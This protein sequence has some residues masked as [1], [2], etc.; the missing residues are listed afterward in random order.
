[1]ISG[2]VYA[3]SSLDN[4]VPEPLDFVP[5]TVVTHPAEDFILEHQFTDFRPNKLLVTSGWIL[6]GLKY[7]SAIDEFHSYVPFD[8]RAFTPY[9]FSELNSSLT[10]NYL[11]IHKH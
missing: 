1:M 7:D 9:S 3:Q 6:R 11:I 2:L 4:S 5:K 8:E 10:K